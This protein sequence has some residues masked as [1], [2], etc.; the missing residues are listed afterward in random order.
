MVKKTG[1]FFP[2]C[3][4][5]TLHMLVC[6]REPRRLCI[7]I[8]QNDSVQ[9]GHHQVLQKLD[10]VVLQPKAHAKFHILPLFFMAC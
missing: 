2:K 5:V 6:A 9:A 8:T 1:I 3:G 7:R 4:D 10:S